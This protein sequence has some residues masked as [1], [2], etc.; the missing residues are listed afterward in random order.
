MAL[1]SPAT[2]NSSCK[3]GPQLSGPPKVKIF[4]GNGV[5]ALVNAIVSPISSS[6]IAFDIVDSGSGYT[7]NTFISIED[8]SGKGKGASAKVNVKKTGV[9]TRIGGTTKIVGGT[10][11]TRGGTTSTAGGTTSTAGGTTSITGAITTIS[12]DSNITSGDTITVTDGTTT[13][14]GGNSTTT[15]NTITITG[16][17]STTIGG[18]TTTT[19]DNSVSVG[20]I[21]TTTGS[22]IEIDGNNITITGGVTTIAKSNNDDYGVSN[23]SILSSGDGYLT[24]P[25]GSLCGNGFVWKE[26]DEGYVV[27]ADE[28]YLVVQI[29]RP[30]DVYPGDVYYPPNGSSR[31]ITSPETITLD[32]EPVT[33]PIS[34]DVGNPYKVILSIEEVVILDPGFGY[35]PEDKI[36]ITPDNGAVLEP[37]INSRGQI[38][39]VNVIS[40]GIGFDDIPEIKTNSPTG[41]NAQ[42]NPIFKVTRLNENIALDIPKNATIITVIDCVGNF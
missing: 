38:E 15:G 16:A 21:I 24:G 23:I 37:V 10:I 39:S 35:R 20:D 40:G 5:G 4:G 32:L 7:D 11:T 25:D 8:P 28:S 22:N 42:M 36:I 3:T 14:S 34:K 17:T 31:E 6:I 18:N 19:G 33:P 29:N 12:G 2:T 1:F 41:F 26:P 27:T 9:R 30:V 13:I